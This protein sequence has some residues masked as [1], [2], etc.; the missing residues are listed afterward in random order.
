[1]KFNNLKDNSYLL[2]KIIWY[3][4][5][6]FGYI[7]NIL[8][9]KAAIYIYFCNINNK[10]YIGSTVNL[11][12]RIS[13]HRSRIFNWSKYKNNNSSLL[14][15]T[16]LKYGW[17]NFQLGVL[18]YIDLSQIA[19]SKDKKLIILDKEQ[20]YLNILNPFLN[21]YKKANSSLGAKRSPNF[22]IKA[23]KIRRGKGK[24]WNMYTQKITKLVTPETKNKISLNNQGIYVKVFDKFNNFLFEF[25]SLRSTAKFFGVDPKTINNIYKTG[26]SFDEYNYKF[27]VKDTRIQVFNPNFELIE[28]F[29]NITKTS[30]RYNIPLSTL[31]NYIKLRKLYKNKFYFYK[32]NVET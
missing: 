2:N 18:E 28:T 22:S 12:A 5:N 11:S 29:R 32:I 7:D 25:S 24:K 26:R 31:S 19:D 13:T 1:M 9:N 8:Q 21:L 27:Y 23:S 16:I 17:I 30:E 15:E 3:N 20:Y 14:Y 4:I 6:R 10:Y